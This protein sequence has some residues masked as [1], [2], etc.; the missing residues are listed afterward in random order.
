MHSS[1]VVNK[2]KSIPG[3]NSAVKAHHANARKA[4]L[5]WRNFGKPS[6]GQLFDKMIRYRKILKS[7]LRKC[8]HNAEMHKANAVA[9]ALHSDPSKKRFWDKLKSYNAKGRSMLPTTVGGASGGQQTADMWREHY[10]HLLNSCK[11]DSNVKLF[12]E[13]KINQVCN[14]TDMKDFYCDVAMLRPLLHKLPLRSATGIDNISAEH[15]SF[16]DPCIV[17]YLSLYFNMC[18]MHGFIPSNCL[19]TVINPI[20]KNRNGNVQDT[21]N[22]R[23]IALATVISKL[24]EHVILAHIAP[25]CMSSDHQFGFKSK[26]STDMCVFLL[27]QAVSFYNKHDTPVYATFLDASK[28]YDRVDHFMLFKK[29]ILCN[30]PL[31]LVRL[32]LYWYKSQM[33]CIKWGSHFSEFF[34]VSNGVRQGGVLSPYLF[35]LYLNDLSTNLNAIKSG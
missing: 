15:L 13:S 2:V 29:M 8:K 18:L 10:A 21:S 28:A 30:I 27:K 31:C 16:A 9:D 14:F 6:N 7:E 35:A 34:G 11:G 17:V 5:E 12:V 25:M 24:F 3:W 23:P 1:A 26:H 4:Y 22:Y 19:E 20:L 33:L 32:L